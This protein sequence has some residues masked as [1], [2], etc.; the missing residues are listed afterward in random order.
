QCFL[1]GKNFQEVLTQIYILL[2][3]LQDLWDIE[4]LEDKDLKSSIIHFPYGINGRTGTIS[5]CIGNGQQ[6]SFAMMNLA[7]YRDTEP[8][9]EITLDKCRDALQKISE[10]PPYRPFFVILHQLGIEADIA[11]VKTD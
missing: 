10:L 4:L 8:E 7:F 1:R 9:G 3:C 5:L 2:K 6:E 11:D